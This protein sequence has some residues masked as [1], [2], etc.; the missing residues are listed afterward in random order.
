MT[1][2]VLL[3]P[4]DVWRIGSLISMRRD[5]AS[6]AGI[7]VLEPYATDIVVRVEDGKLDPRDFDR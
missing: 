7:L 2:S 3:A 4:S 6:D 5:I 1:L